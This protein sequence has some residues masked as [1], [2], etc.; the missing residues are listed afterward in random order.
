MSIEYLF[1]YRTK[2][3]KNPERNEGAKA[4]VLCLFFFENCSESFRE[5]LHAN[6]NN[7]NSMRKLHFEFLICLEVAF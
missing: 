2:Q 3:K 5:V 7:V 4:R 1:S 6:D